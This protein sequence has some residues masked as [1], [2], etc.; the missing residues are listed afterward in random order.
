MHLL[1][2]L[3][4]KRMKKCESEEICYQIENKRFCSSESKE[5]KNLN[6][7]KIKKKRENKT[8]IL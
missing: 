7:I 5:I 6:N 2:T 4:K 8:L 1:S 3:N